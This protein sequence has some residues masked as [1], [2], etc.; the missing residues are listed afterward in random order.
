MGQNGQ[1][2]KCTILSLTMAVLT[3]LT[4]R[5][6]AGDGPQPGEAGREDNSGVASLSAGHDVSLACGRRM[7]YTFGLRQAKC[8]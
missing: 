4:C 6:S 2:S 7:P 5:L 3:C 8:P 1:S